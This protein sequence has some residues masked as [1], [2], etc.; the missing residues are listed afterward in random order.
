[1]TKDWTGNSN[2]IYKTLGA[3]SHSDSDREIN[4]YYATDLRDMELLLEQETFE[5]VWECACGGGHLAKVL[6][7]H[8]ILA[9]ASDMYYKCYG[10]PDVDFF[11]VNSWN[12]DIVTNPPYK[13]AQEFIEHALAII[14]TGRKVAMF[15][16]V[17][18]LEG[19][20]RKLMFLQNPP[21]V[22]YVSISRL[23]CA[24]NGNF[25][26]EKGVISSSSVAYAWYVWSKGYG[27][28][29]IV[30]WIN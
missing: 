8:G 6:D 23:L 16:K 10:E 26:N 2:S 25:N 3:S 12:G 29:T 27:G 17:Q 13:Y 28:N 20:R 9:R 24:K 1:M 21:K 14:E 22:I 30:L 11:G 15:L 5:N 4:D 7:S 19:K 18:F